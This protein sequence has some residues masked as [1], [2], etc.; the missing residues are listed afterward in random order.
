M[1]KEVW[2]RHGLKIGTNTIPMRPGARVVHF[3]DQ[4]DSFTIWYE[5]TVPGWSHQDDATIVDLAR[6]FSIVATGETIP[7]DWR[8]IGTCIRPT[9]VWHLYEIPRRS[10]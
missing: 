10:L 6:Q 5:T 8:Y 7:D 9:T 2:K 4:F 1:A 3:G